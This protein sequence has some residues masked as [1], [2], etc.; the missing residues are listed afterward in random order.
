MNT[1][2]LEVDGLCKS[3]GG[4]KALRDLSFNMRRGEVLGLIGPNGSGKSTT[5]NM[6]SGAMPASSGEIRL[7]GTR[8]ETLSQWDRVGLG[9][10]RTYQTASVFPEFTVRQHVTL[11]CEGRRG[12]G[13]LA[14]AFRLRRD[15][16]DDSRIKERV[17]KALELTGLVDQADH[18]VGTLSTAQ[19]RF[20]MIATALTSDPCVILLDEPAAG[21]ISHERETLSGMIGRIRD[22]GIS[23]LVIEHHMALIMEVCDRIVV[24]NFGAPIAQGTPREIRENRAVID[25]YLGEAA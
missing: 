5:V 20:L 1:D 3:F 14:Q 8:I 19:Q 21:M 18:I 15:P 17:A 12:V 6:L 25:A 2:V 23:V 16:A 22:A 13:P 4:V 9:L 24:L 7:N 10:T 11:G